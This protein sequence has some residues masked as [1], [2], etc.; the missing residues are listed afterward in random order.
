M[1]SKDRLILSLASLGI[2]VGV[3]GCGGESTLMRPTSTALAG[4]KVPT[5][6][7][8]K[9]RSGITLEHLGFDYSKSWILNLGENVH[10]GMADLLNASQKR[11]IAVNP[12]GLDYW[13]RYCSVDRSSI[14]I[15]ATF[16]DGG[17]IQSIETGFSIN[18]AT[19]KFGL[20]G[21]LIFTMRDLDSKY[22]VSPVNKDL[23]GSKLASLWGT[24]RMIDL[25]CASGPMSQAIASGNTETAGI[26]DRSRD[27]AN[28]FEVPLLNGQQPLIFM[29]TL[30]I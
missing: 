6:I 24:I 30:G 27:L 28:S 16:A 18:R 29:I 7:T 3:T 22:Q 21:L 13:L 10:N 23:A 15:Q 19:I 12:E 14:Q 2:A 25:M 1:G 4:D 26:L 17:N 8:E 5:P 9:R 20:D 11:R